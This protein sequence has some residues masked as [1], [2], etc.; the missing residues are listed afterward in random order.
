[1]LTGKATKADAAECKSLI[2]PP[3]PPTAADPP[4]DDPKGNS[5][6]KLEKSGGRLLN[7]FGVARERIGVVRDSE[8]VET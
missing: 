3:P 4:A 5:P 7:R 2:P 1:M 8:L 6:V